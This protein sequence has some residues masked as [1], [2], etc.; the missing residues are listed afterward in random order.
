MRA[1]KRI[2]FS[3]ANY[4]QVYLVGIRLSAASGGPEYYSLVLYN[5]VARNDKNRPLTREKRIVLFSQIA[6]ADSVLRMGDVAF[7]KYSPFTGEVAYV[8]DVPQLV[9]LLQHGERD[10]GALVLNFINELLDFVAAT[11]VRMPEWAKV[12]LESLADHATFNSNLG[13]YFD[14]GGHSRSQALDAVL[15]SLGAIVSSAEVVL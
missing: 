7:R 15:W 12:T 13:E 4:E 3:E 10:E 14:Q 11:M 1:D 9:A 6:S 2:A 8:Y 5:E